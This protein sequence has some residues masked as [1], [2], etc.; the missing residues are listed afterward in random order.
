MHCGRA[1]AD[2]ERTP[3]RLLGC[4]S[5]SVGGR[6]EWC[7]ALEFLTGSPADDD[8]VRLAHHTDQR[9]S[10]MDDDADLVATPRAAGNVRL[11]QEP[12]EGLV[13]LQGPQG[14]PTAEDRRGPSCPTGETTKFCCSQQLC[15]AD[16]AAESRD[17]PHDVPPPSLL[18]RCILAGIPRRHKRPSPA[19]PTEEPGRS[20]PGRKPRQAARRSRS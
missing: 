10:R 1:L 13:R 2:P 7:D 5:R 15:P 11:R 14:L 18:R 19:S 20:S 4:S 9:P 16:A 6:D 3:R 17:A 12:R 8:K